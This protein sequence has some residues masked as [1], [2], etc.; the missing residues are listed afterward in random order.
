MGSAHEVWLEPE[1]F[2]GSKGQEKTVS[3]K[4]GENFA[5]IN[6]PYLNTRFK[7]FFTFQNGARTD[8]QGRAGNIPA[9]KVSPVNDGL[10][11][12]VYE[13]TSSIIT[14][15]DWDKF[16]A[17]ATHKGQDHALST[18]HRMGWP[19]ENF[20]E[21]YFRYVKALMGIGPSRGEDINHGLLLEF[22]ALD[23]PYE[24]TER[25]TIEVQLFFKDRPVNDAQIQIF[26]R[27]TSGFVR[28]FTQNTDE[29]GKTKVP[30]KPQHTY[31][32]DSV[33]LRP[34]DPKQHQGVLWESL[35]T[36][37]TFATPA[38]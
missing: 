13:S 16:V 34:A 26:E 15:R 35:W 17:F 6:L 23:N 19:K 1:T 10:M 24:P 30:V 33:I 20:R 4:N 31:L 2:V 38:K 18:H 11:S 28:I 8:I 36:A 27:D 22:I 5:G 25:E 14:Y 32:I 37:L 7:Q 3:L 12:V 29:T 21:V 9:A